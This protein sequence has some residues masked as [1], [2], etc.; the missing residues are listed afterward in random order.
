L[1]KNAK[2]NLSVWNNKPTSAMKKDTSQSALEFELASGL[3]C[4]G[5]TDEEVLSAYQKWIFMV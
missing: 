5:A 3:M 2:L 1:S 4:V